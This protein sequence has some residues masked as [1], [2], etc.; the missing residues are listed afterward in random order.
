[1]IDNPHIEE[2][3]DQSEEYHG[4][5]LALGRA[6]NSISAVSAGERNEVIKRARQ[7]V[8]ESTILLRNMEN[9][10]TDIR[11]SVSSNEYNEYKRQFTNYKNDLQRQKDGLNRSINR[12]D[13]NKLKG[14]D[15]E[16]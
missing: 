2:F 14:K 4:L 7:R 3:K 15:K 13:F 9:K 16:Q 1:M 8:Q 5:Q 11:R 12:N 6:I 10:L